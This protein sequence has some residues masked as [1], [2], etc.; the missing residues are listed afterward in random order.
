LHLEFNLSHTADW[1]ACV[2]TGGMRCGVDIEHV[3]QIPGILEI[4]RAR[5]APEEFQELQTLEAIAQP[6]RFFEMWT[7]KEAWVKASGAGLSAPIDRAVHNIPQL[8]LRRFEPAQL[9]TMAVVLIHR[10]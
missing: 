1:A 3:R 9:V 10:T 7:A 2:V 6:R 8:T 5:F 4:A